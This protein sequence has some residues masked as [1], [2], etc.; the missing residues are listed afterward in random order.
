M[1]KNKI[2]KKKIIKNNEP[3]TFPF[4]VYVSN[5]SVLYRDPQI[6]PVN[7]YRGIREIQQGMSVCMG[8]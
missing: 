4:E 3:H 7:V 2:K 1:A 8:K 6:V 5:S